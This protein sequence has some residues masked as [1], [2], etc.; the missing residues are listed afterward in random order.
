MSKSFKQTYNNTGFYFLILFACVFLAFFNTYFKIFPGFKSSIK[1]ANVIHFHALVSF[2]WM[3]LLIAQPI[4]IKYKKVALHRTLGKLTYV[5]APLIIGSFIALMYVKYAEGDMN[6]W[7]L[8]NIVYY[9][10]FQILH[11]I[12]FTAFYTLAII[13]K[14]RHNISLHSGYMVA[15]GLIFINPVM[16]RFFYNGLGTSFPTAE[17]IALILTDIATILLL[18]SA[19]KHNTNYKFYFIILML[20]ALYQIPMVKLMY[21][22][23]P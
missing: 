10:Y 23:H 21:F 20:F 16:R 2:L 3:V 14:Y 15:T 12:F 9:F 13:N 17:T 7:P 1:S 4:L 19:R 18:L 5:L 11:T 22:Y 6:K 8:V